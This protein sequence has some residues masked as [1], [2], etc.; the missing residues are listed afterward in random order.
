M[1]AD[2]LRHPKS[3]NGIFTALNLIR[4]LQIQLIKN[5]AMKDNRVDYACGVY[6]RSSF[7]S[8]YVSEASGSPHDLL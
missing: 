7:H 3:E 5:M 2:N 6:R 1:I 4:K 8:S